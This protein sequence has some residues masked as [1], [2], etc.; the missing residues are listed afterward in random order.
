MCPQL[1]P[2]GFM[3]SICWDYM[4]L[5]CSVFFCASAVSIP[6]I[7]TFNFSQSLWFCFMTFSVRSGISKPSCLLQPSGFENRGLVSRSFWLTASPDSQRSSKVKSLK[8]ELRLH[9]IELCDFY[10]GSVFTFIFG[11]LWTFWRVLHQIP[12]GG[13]VAMGRSKFQPIKFELA[14]SFLVHFQVTACI[15]VSGFNAQSLPAP[16]KFGLKSV[17]PWSA[18]HWRL[19][20]TIWHCGAHFKGWEIESNISPN[21]FLF[22][23]VCIFSLICRFFRLSDITDQ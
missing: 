23:S 6:S 1:L 2:L 5:H 16:C 18:A 17:W 21:H 12:F 15:Q 13:A 8:P 10:W 4:F 11:S 14:F 22:F 7:K 19:H 20:L 3:C 9:C